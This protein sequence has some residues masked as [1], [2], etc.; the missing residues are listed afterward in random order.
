MATSQVI[1]WFR[2]Q[3]EQGLYEDLIVECIKLYGYDIY[4]LPAQRIREDDLF[5]EDVL[6]KFPDAIEIEAYIENIEGFGGMGE[7]FSKFGI[8]I[9]DMITF[10]IATKRWDEVKKGETI[11]S[12]DGYP[13]LPETVTTTNGPGVQDSLK[14]EVQTYDYSSQYRP[15]EGDLIYF[16][17]VRKLFEIRF[18]EH[19][20]F[21]YP[22]GRRMIYQLKCE[23]YQS[24]S[25][26]FD[27]G[28]PEID[29]IETATS[30]DKGFDRI[31]A[32]DGSL[33]LAEDGTSYIVNEQFRVET[34]E[35]LAN[36][37]LF[38]GSVLG[39]VDFSE[40]NPFVSGKR[41]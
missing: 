13:L 23:M 15:N 32:E 8:E 11:L 21:F 36:N 7:T 2:S 41:Y 10:I 34:V 18:V 1:S 4:Y 24:S 20:K 17:L 38:E 14:D 26:K 3:N 9:N 12:E 5:G 35:P 30:A 40:S 27:T 22:L 6:T 31:L 19:E 39:I 28:I 37:E 33:I 16:P 25:E 29:A